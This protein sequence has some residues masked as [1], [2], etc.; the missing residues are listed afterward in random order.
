MDAQKARAR[1][2]TAVDTE[3]WVV[4]REAEG[5][6]FVGYDALQ[7]EVEIMKYRKVKTA[8]KTYYQVVFNKTP[9]YAESGGQV[10]DTGIIED[11]NG[12]LWKVQD[13]KKENNLPVHIMEVLP[14]AVDQTFKAMVDA[15]KREK[16][17]NNHS[18]THLLHAALKKVL[19][20]HVNQKG[21]LVN[22]E[23]LRF[24]VT[25]FQKMSAEELN[26]IEY[27]VNE[28]IRE[29]I[30]LEE[31]RNVPLKEAQQMGAMALFGE[32]YGDSVRVIV[33]DR[34]FSMELCG[35]THV[36]NTAQIGYCKIVS[37]GAV[38]AGVR[39]LE[40]IT[41]EKAM[42][43]FEAKEKELESVKALLNNPK[44]ISKAISTLQEEN[45]LLR[46]RLEK[47]EAEKVASLVDTLKSNFNEANGYRYLVQQVSVPG[48]EA[49]KNASMQLKQDMKDMVCVLV[50]VLDGKPLINVVVS[51]SLVASKTFHAGNMVKELA[52]EI[53]GGGGGQPGYASAGGADVNG[54][55]KVLHKALTMVSEGK[56]MLT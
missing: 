7:C 33:F 32:K 28:K 53:K 27:M 2:A 36:K 15:E 52:R 21:S 16:I 9:F 31:L 38:A 30:L 46:K 40:A 49:L 14:D 8:Q 26:V 44:D 51:D 10:G 11:A 18:A 55:D 47:F 12:K 20:A 54:I 23:Y 34:N 25:H 17:S 1:N 45:A 37:E 22:D 4:C 39:R 43:Y 35:G 24:D 50:S 5:C 3:D 41:G 19:G 48:A 56:M 29:N 6:D 42:A 13:T